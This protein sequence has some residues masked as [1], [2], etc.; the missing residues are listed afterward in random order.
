M[1]V[2]QNQNLTNLN[3][4]LNAN[5]G[6]SNPTVLQDIKALQEKMTLV[7]AEYHQLVENNRKLQDE[8][9]LHEKIKDLLLNPQTFPI[10]MQKLQ[11]TIE[12]YSSSLANLDK[13]AEKTLSVLGI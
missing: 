4:V 7:M 5:I 11:F 9:E 3:E 2:N 6:L 10:E 12:T 8:I 13:E 1:Q